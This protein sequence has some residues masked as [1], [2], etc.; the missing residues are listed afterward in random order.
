[1]KSNFLLYTAFTFVVL[2][3]A[4]S[5]QNSQNSDVP[6]AETAQNE[7]EMANKGQPVAPMDESSETND[8][9]PAKD[10]KPI[11]ILYLGD[12]ITA[13]YGLGEEQAFPN[14]V[15]EKAAAAGFSTITVNAGVSGD[16]STGGLNRLSWLLKNQVDILVLELG[17]NDGLRGVDLDLTAS[18][19]S[20]IIDQ[21][22][23]VWPN[24]K[25][26]VAGMMVPPNLGH[27]YTT[28]FREIFPALAQN[29]N[30][31]LIPF[32][33]DG[34]GGIKELNQPDGIHPTAKGHQIVAE[35]VWN[36]IAPLLDGM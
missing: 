15:Q 1:M 6:A 35:T 22:K 34:V 18:N 14:L 19:L 11:R 8:L 20:Q 2:I 28:S 16:T 32:V 24:V 7:S 31:E 33:L 17:G 23:K 26:V 5:N 4:C 29:H 30:A 21:T 36:A 13:G 10:S 3:S 9:N 12:S 27:E 25:V